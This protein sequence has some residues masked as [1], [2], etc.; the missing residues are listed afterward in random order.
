MLKS[1][2]L[3][4]AL[5]VVLPLQQGSDL[6]PTGTLRA[7]FIANNPV[8]GRVDP[9]T[10]AISGPVPDLVREL[11]KRL[12][13]PARIIPTDSA[14]AVIDEV[15]T[16][17]ADIGFVTY[18]DERAKK[19]DFSE[20][21]VVSASAY[22]VRVDSSIKSSA[23]VDRPDVTIGAINGQTQ[24]LYISENMRRARVEVLPVAP[25]PDAIAALLISR[26]VDVFGANRQRMEEAARTSA[27]LRVLSDNFMVTAQ[28]IIVKK[29]HPSR[30]AELNRFLAG[31]K[32]SG[33]VKASLDRANAAGV[34]VAP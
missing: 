28:A 19:V 16:H 7:A 20:A 6:A 21:Y 32:N 30:L 26:K 8:Q 29:G 34:E 12:G 14:E 9:Q 31:V 24:Q 27:Q 25:P 3:L 22:L 5:I 2:S 13:V 17:R 10:G 11:A 15:T 1:L 4:I 23:D 33:F 18:N